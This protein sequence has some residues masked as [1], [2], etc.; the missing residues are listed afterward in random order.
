MDFS[1]LKKN[2][3]SIEELSKKFETASGGG[4]R[5]VDSRILQLA[6]SRDKEGNA[7]KVIRLLPIGSNDSEAGLD[8]PFVKKITYGFKGNGGWYFQTSRKTIGEDD[9]VYDENGKDYGLDTDT[10]KNRAKNRK[11]L[12][13]Y[14]SN[15]Y[16]V[17]DKENPEND[18][19]VM[20]LE[21]GPLL[22]KMFQAALKPKFEDDPKFDPFDLWEG[23]DFKIK[24]FSEDKG[25]DSNGKPT[26]MPNYD[27]STFSICAALFDDDEKLKAVWDQCHSLIELVDPTKIKSYEELSKELDRALGRSSK[28]EASKQEDHE[29]SSGVED[30]P[31]PKTD[32]GTVDHSFDESD[33]SSEDS[34]LD[35]FKNLAKGGS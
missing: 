15:V 6:P 30:A 17:K 1:K 23:A 8:N 10:S 2:R 26:I 18:G 14:Y 13:K 4:K 21:Y 27:K 35:F 24:I 16:V 19:T 7:Y 29:D 3:P 33:D 34:D 20:L 22:F 25:K 28:H 5:E 32:S 11:Q 31:E 9:P 12:V